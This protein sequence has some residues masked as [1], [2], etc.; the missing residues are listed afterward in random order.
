MVTKFAAGLTAVMVA[1]SLFSIWYMAEANRVA[2][3]NTV[4]GLGCP[5]P[6][7]EHPGIPCRIK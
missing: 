3:I 2:G 5:A 7:H 4:N 1:G 6:L